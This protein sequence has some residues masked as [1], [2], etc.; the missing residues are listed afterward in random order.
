MTGPRCSTFTSAWYT[1]RRSTGGPPMLFEALEPRQLLAAIFW[2]GGGGDL[3]WHNPLNW[4]GDVLPGADD[5]VMLN[6]PGITVV[7]DQ[8]VTTAVHSLW[9]LSPLEL[10]GGVIASATQWRQA[11]PLSITGG[12]VGGAGDL[13]VNSS[14]SWTAGV[15]LGSGRTLILPGRELRIAGDVSLARQIVNNGSLVWESGDIT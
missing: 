7:H 14:V 10:R 8:D 3:L 5:D 6:A 11:A 12:S 9:A 13:L 4:S 2:D 15:M 1:R